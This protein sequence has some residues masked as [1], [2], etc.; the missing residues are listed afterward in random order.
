MKRELTETRPLRSDPNDV[1][2]R[3]LGE[4]YRQYRR[5]WEDV[6]AFRNESRTPIHLDFELNYSCNLR[7]IL[8]PHGIPGAPRPA[9]AKERMPFGLFQRVVG[10]GAAKDLRAV[11]LSQ[12]NEPLLRKDL[13]K[14]ARCARAAGV[15]DVM[16]NTN[17]MLLTAER[18]RRLIES[19][20][21]QLRV[22]IDAATA[23]T[24]AKVR[25]GGDYGAVVAN[26]RGF[27]RTRNDMGRALPL[28]RVSFVRCALN[29][30]E[31]DAFLDAWR[32]EADFC[33][34][35]DYASWVENDAGANQKYAEPL[36]G[37]RS[38]AE[39]ACVQPWQRGTV[40]ANGDFIPCCSELYRPNPAGNLRRQGLEEIWT[41]PGL[42]ALRKAQR[43][44][45]W[46]A[47]ETCR[48]CVAM[49]RAE[50]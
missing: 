39:F 30:H 8:C 1:L 25:Q 15:L 20:L 35:S 5:A 22:S 4:P 21:T 2:V 12:L 14:F 16:I 10:E 43:D 11:R 40:F 18:S 31:L 23:A 44:G 48:R 45:T 49:S 37:H 3:E 27:L 6:S 34:V 42:R 28:L 38:L 7:C 50:A 26:I 29:S 32:D 17:G 9:Y 36:D 47:F 19:G 13:E 46:R 33:A 24:Y 41:S